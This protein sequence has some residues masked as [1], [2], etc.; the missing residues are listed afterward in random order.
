VEELGKGDND[1]AIASFDA[2]IRVNPRDAAA[3]FLRGT[4]Q[5]RKGNVDKAIR[6]YTEALR[7]DPN[8]PAAYVR[9]GLAYDRQWELDKAIADYT[10]GI[11]RDPKVANTF[12]LRAVSYAKKRENGKAVQDCTAAL[13]LDPN[14][15]SAYTQRGIA[16]ADD[17]KYTTAVRDYAAAIKLNAKY[18]VAYQRLAW[19]RA[20]CPK[21]ELRDGKQ[22][23]AYAR[24]VCD[25]SDR[26]HPHDLETLAAAC[27]ENGL[28]D[29]AVKWQYRALENQDYRPEELGEARMRL[30]LYEQ[31]KPYRELPRHGG[32]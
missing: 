25:L 11:R 12:I 31:R 16:Q 18:F 22:A 2:A 27:A 6:D 24:M 4:A 5:F 7:L 17:G 30:K 32:D 20:T 19:L 28:F 15:A 29:E 10:E 21:T 13:L 26:K 1:R 14:N 8:L 23:L 3:Y 9:R